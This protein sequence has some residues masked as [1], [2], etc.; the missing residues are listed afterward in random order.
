[1]CKAFIVILLLEYDFSKEKSSFDFFNDDTNIIISE[2]LRHAHPLIL[3]S[4]VTISIMMV[5]ELKNLMHAACT[6]QNI[7]FVYAH[8]VKKRIAKKIHSMDVAIFDCRFV[9]GKS[10][11]VA[12]YWQNKIK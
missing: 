11:F 3:V 5:L 9:K 8:I 12:I 6:D 1:M 2:R 10:I 4:R 7:H